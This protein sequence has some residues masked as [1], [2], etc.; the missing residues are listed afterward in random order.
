M[1]LTADCLTSVGAIALKFPHILPLFVT[2]SER[3]IERLTVAYSYKSDKIYLIV[4]HVNFPVQ[5]ML[6]K[7]ML[8]VGLTKMTNRCII[9]KI[10]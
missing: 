7:L 3:L 4:R 10:F 5:E 9:T 8:S 1:E 2:G 6:T